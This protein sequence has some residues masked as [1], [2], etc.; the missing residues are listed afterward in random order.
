[1]AILTQEN[2]L[3][4]L[5]EFSIENYSQWWNFFRV[6]LFGNPDPERESSNPG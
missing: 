5:A 6:L 1:M 3:A 4:T 2:H